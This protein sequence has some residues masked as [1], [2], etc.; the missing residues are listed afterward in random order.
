MKLIPTKRQL[1]NERALQR[2]KGPKPAEH[3]KGPK[4]VKNFI[5]AAEHLGRYEST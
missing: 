3:T 1:C 2:T 4:P 5:I